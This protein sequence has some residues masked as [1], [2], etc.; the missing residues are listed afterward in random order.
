MQEAKLHEHLSATRTKW[1]FEVKPNNPGKGRVLR[2]RLLPSGSPTN[3]TRHVPYCSKEGGFRKQQT[4][5]F[6]T[7]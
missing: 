3:Y 5:H 2:V 4:S 7:I 1:Y 6:D